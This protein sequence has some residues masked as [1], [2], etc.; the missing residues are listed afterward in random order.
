MLTAQ[1]IF[2]HLEAT[3]P[4]PLATE[5]TL[6][7]ALTSF[8]PDSNAAPV[9]VA[10]W[11]FGENELCFSW[12]SD[13][14]NEVF[15]DKHFYIGSGAKVF[16]RLAGFGSSERVKSI[17]ASLSQ[18]LTLAAN[19]LVDEIG[20]QRNLGERF[21]F[22]YEIL[23]RHNGRLEYLSDVSYAFAEVG[24]TASGQL[25]GKRL[26]QNVY[27]YQARDECAVIDH[28]THTQ[29]GGG[30]IRNIDRHL[31][32]PLV[33]D[34][35]AQDARLQRELTR[36]IQPLFTHAKM[37]CVI[38]VLIHAVDTPHPIVLP[39]FVTVGTE[40]AQAPKVDVIYSP[41]PVL[42]VRL[43]SDK[44]I[45]RVYDDAMKGEQKSRG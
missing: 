23:Y 20:A 43:V 30:L 31:I 26:N 2:S 41:K 34:A 5:E 13:W 39:T 9:Q 25:Q 29:T 4:E 37:S 11:I 44:I 18:A 24:F 28:S 22:A 42:R 33:G 15:A 7:T 6:R 32:T 21:G 40:N 45:R 12:R 14:P 1:A 36:P 3:L 35:R 10:G 27:Q 19:L 17:G 16:E 8:A 38:L